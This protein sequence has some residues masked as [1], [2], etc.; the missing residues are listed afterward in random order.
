MIFKFTFILKKDKGELYYKKI[1]RFTLILI[2]GI[3][4]WRKKRAKKERDS[5]FI[6]YQSNYFTITKIKTVTIIYLFK[7]EEVLIKISIRGDLKAEVNSFNN[8]NNKGL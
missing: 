4:D 1:T 5:L 8:R 3:K 7:P 6:I 2:R